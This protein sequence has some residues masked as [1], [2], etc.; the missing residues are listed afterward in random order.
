M[1]EYKQSYLILWQAI[2]DAL[3]ELEA[4]NLGTAKTILLQGQLSAE[5]A[6]ISQENGQ[7]V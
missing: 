6:Y 1:D 7:V 4:Q 5:E 3:Q 2:T